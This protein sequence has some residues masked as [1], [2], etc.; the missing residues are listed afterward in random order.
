MHV[1]VFI[2]MHT[3]TVYDPHTYIKPMHI[4]IC[5]WLRKIAGHRSNDTTISVNYKDSYCL[6]IGWHC[7]QQS[8][9]GEI[10]GSRT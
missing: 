5:I 9:H 3:Y 7:K 1:A 8:W 4:L 10:D 6:E 2:D